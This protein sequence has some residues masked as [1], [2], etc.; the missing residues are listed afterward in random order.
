MTRSS[1]PSYVPVDAPVNVIA[2]GFLSE[3]VE[4]GNAL[5]SFAVKVISAFNALPFT[6]REV[7]TA[8]T[9]LAVVGTVMFIDLSVA[10]LVVK[11]STVVPF[12]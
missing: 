5:T 10:A 11:L 7:G 12:F 3:V 9:S 1:L 8:P 4:A 6:V 2:L